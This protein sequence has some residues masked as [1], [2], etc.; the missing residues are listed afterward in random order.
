MDDSDE[1]CLIVLKSLITVGFKSRLPN[2]I[3]RFGLLSV[4]N[5]PYRA[6]HLPNFSCFFTI[7]TV[8]VCCPPPCLSLT[9]SLLFLRIY[10]NTL[11]SPR[12]SEQG[13]SSIFITLPQHV[14]FSSRTFPFHLWHREL[15]NTLPRFTVILSISAPSNFL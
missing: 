3:S 10:P 1:H 7:P 14:L 2:K 4:F 9:F 13:I 12:G 11:P 8:D 6:K 5:P 15:N